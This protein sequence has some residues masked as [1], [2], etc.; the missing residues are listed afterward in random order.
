MVG[1]AGRSGL[2]EGVPGPEGCLANCVTPGAGSQVALVTG[3]MSAMAAN[4]P[5]CDLPASL[6]VVIINWPQAAT[7]C[8]QVFVPITRR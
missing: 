4:P 6:R 1:S 8:S 2:A 5:L 7:T 3:A